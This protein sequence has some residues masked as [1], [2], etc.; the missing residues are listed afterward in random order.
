VK[1]SGWKTI[2]LGLFVLI[3]AGLLMIGIYYVGQKQRLFSTVFRVNGVFKNVSGL[4]VGNNVRFS[5]ITVGTVESIEIIADTSVKVEMIIDEKTRKFIKKDARAV[6]GSEGLMGNKVINITPGTENAGLINNNDYIRTG[7]PLEIDEIWAQLK[8]T[9]DNAA[10]ITTDLASIISNIRSG[11]GSIGKLLMDTT[12][13]ENL[14]Q[15]ITNVQRGA[16]GFEENMSAAKQSF[17]LKG[18]FKKKKKKKKN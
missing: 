5:G 14:D 3:G 1:Q 10:T 12:F 4:Q 2:V 17:L 9:S 11:K 7:Q 16:K 6:I 15:T 8:K 13:A 18:F